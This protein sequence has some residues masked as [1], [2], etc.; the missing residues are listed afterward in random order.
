LSLNAVSTSIYS[1]TF[2]TYIFWWLAGLSIQ[3]GIVNDV[4]PVTLFKK[5]KKKVPKEGD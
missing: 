5:K 2:T 4:N 1:V 3:K